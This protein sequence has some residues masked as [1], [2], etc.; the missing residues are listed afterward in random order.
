MVRKIGIILL[1]YSNIVVAADNHSVGDASSVGTDSPVAHEHIAAHAPVGPAHLAP[2]G[3]L[4][5]RGWWNKSKVLLPAAAGVAG[6]GLGISAGVWIGYAIADSR[7]GDCHARFTALA[8]CIN[9][10]TGFYYDAIATCF[11]SGSGR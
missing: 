2:V 7:V 6:L 5:R 4:Q 1:I 8:E 11:H 3:N 9:A 10:N